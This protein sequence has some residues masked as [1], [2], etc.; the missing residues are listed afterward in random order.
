MNNNCCDISLTPQKSREV[1]NFRD[2]SREVEESNKPLT[3]LIS[4]SVVEL[5]IL[6]LNLL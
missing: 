3:F 5:S 1:Y 6:Q 4:R 2:C